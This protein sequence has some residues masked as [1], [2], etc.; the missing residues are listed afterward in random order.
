[1][2]VNAIHDYAVSTSEEEL[3]EDDD[4]DPEKMLIVN[5]SLYIFMLRQKCEL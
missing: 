1:M 2:F 5:I 4:T 3:E